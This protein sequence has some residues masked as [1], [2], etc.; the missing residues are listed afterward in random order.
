MRI[1]LSYP[2]A[3]VASFMF[4]SHARAVDVNAGDYT[5][6][7]AGTNVALWYQQY[8]RSDQYHP[9]NGSTNRAGTSLKSNIS[10]VRLIHFMKVGGIT[11]D[12]QILLPFG[13]VYDARISGQSLSSATGLADPI[14]GATFWLVNQPAAG[15]SGR[16]FGITP[17][18]YL[19]FGSYDK[20]DALNLG[21]NRFKGD[22]Q[23][24][25]IEPLWGKISFELYGDAVFYGH[26]NDAGNG[27]QTLKQDPTYQIQTNLRYDFDPTR[28]VAFGYSAITGGKQFLESDYTGQK[29]QVQQVR[30]EYQQMVNRSVQLSA[31]LT[32]DTHVDGGFQEDIGINLRALLVF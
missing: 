10:I 19:P 16:Y 6:L 22:L 31:Q 27:N 3:L 4:S 25:W 18:I 13:H 8:S 23:L 29:T 20:H 21:E 32:H 14:I 2:A 7:P 12:P 26:N 24:G 9:D 11:I 30:V 28:R 17:L 5:A 1:S 15:M